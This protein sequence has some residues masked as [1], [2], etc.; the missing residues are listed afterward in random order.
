MK[1][2]INLQPKDVAVGFIGLGVMGSCIA[3]HL[4]KAGYS[5]Y[6]H[7]RSQHKL[8]TLVES[9]AI[10]CKD[11][12]TVAQHADILFSMVG[13]PKDVRDIYFGEQGILAH[14][15]PGTVLCDL[16]TSEPDLANEIFLAG[17]AK[18]LASLD[19]PVT[20]GDRG[21]R[22]GTLT[23][24]VGGEKETFDIMYPIFQIFGKKIVYFGRAGS[25]QHAKMANQI[26][27]SGSI[28][29]LIESLW[30]AKQIGLDLSVV[31]DT[32]GSGAAGSWSIANYGP[33]ILKG[34][35]APGF[36]IKHF[37]KDMEIALKQAKSNGLDLPALE[38]ALQ[39]YQR[40][41]QSG[42]EDLGIQGLYKLQEKLQHTQKDV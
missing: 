38:T 17:Q 41:A 24:M 42:G 16:T 39:V 40:A 31:L 33:R 6:V 26:A 20:G 35:F 1:E 34:D 10:L 9:G 13:F 27:I 36:F 8:Q 25:G 4:Q 12:A 37:I 22:E 2:F 7:N 5:L 18:G 3:R 11:V 29:G 15:K 28:L 32:I 21:A 14:A 30:Y 23:I 19:A